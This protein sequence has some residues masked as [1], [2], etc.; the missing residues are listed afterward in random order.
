[1]LDLQQ[2][3]QS[4]QI[5]KVELPFN[6]ARGRWRQIAVMHRVTRVAGFLQVLV[7]VR[8][9]FGQAES[10]PFREDLVVAAA[11]RAVGVLAAQHAQEVGVAVPAR[12]G[13]P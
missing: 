1:M 8:F 6:I 5:R 12:G 4:L 13:V 3:H 10:Q 7:H 11:Q 2:P 9:L